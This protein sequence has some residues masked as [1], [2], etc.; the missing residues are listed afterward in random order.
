MQF[1]NSIFS[2][3]LTATTAFRNEPWG[4]PAPLAG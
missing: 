4:T 3:T 2:E 1:F